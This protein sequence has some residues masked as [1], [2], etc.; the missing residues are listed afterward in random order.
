M[1]TRL[2]GEYFDAH[3]VIGM[4]VTQLTIAS[5]AR[6]T[7]DSGTQR[8]LTL[9]YTI[10]PGV[11]S[12]QIS[13]AVP[14]DPLTLDQSSRHAHNDSLH[15]ISVEEKEELGEREF[16]SVDRGSSHERLRVFEF[17]KSILRLL[18]ACLRPDLGDLFPVDNY[19]GAN[20]LKDLT[21]LLVKCEHVVVD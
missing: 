19:F 12:A 10:E 17:A 18:D 14:V 6:A 16:V 7:I 13:Q 11:D 3:Q 2:P 21:N 1:K 5:L 8:K 4:A 15:P 9:T 20:E